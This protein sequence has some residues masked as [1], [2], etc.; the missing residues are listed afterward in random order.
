[1]FLSVH[2]DMSFTCCFAGELEAKTTFSPV[3]SKKDSLFPRHSSMLK[4]GR[5]EQ[6]AAFESFDD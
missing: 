2:P 1:M 6:R 5:K 4:S 3:C